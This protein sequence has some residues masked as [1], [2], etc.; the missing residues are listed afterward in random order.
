MWTGRIQRRK[1]I[2]NGF[3]AG[4]EF[5]KPHGV[6]PGWI[7]AFMVTCVDRVNGLG[8]DNKHYSASLRG[9]LQ[10]IPKTPNPEIIR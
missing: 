5:R 8:R 2:S 1:N 4:K 6:S 10:E 3:T 7:K 9:Q